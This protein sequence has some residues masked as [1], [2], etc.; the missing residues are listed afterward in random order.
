M[1]IGN[2]SVDALGSFAERYPNAVSFYTDPGCKAYAALGMLRGMGGWQ[3]LK[4]VGHVVRAAKGGHRQGATRGSPA[5]QGGVCVFGKGGDLLM[6]HHDTTAGDNLPP[7]R[8]LFFFR[9]HSMAL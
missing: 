3:S 4:M 9:S 7:E 8:V 2:G 1:V 6:A 5:Q